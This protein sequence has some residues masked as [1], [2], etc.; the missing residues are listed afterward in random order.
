M[1]AGRCRVCGDKTAVAY[2]SEELAEGRA[3]MVRKDYCIGC[4]SLLKLGK[5]KEYP[6]RANERWVK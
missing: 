5:L 2:L 4:D 1:K 6:T 3:V